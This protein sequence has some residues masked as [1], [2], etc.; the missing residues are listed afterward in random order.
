MSEKEIMIPLSDVVEML[1]M[2]VT[3]EVPDRQYINHTHLECYQFGLVDAGTMVR[4]AIREALIKK[5]DPTSE[6]EKT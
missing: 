5:Y 6:E 1:A 2:D 3:I 4:K